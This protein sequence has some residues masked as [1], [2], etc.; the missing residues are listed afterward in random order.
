MGEE[1]IRE[2]LFKF[3]MADS[4]FKL[5]EIAG[6]FYIEEFCNDGTRI[7]QEEINNHNRLKTIL[8]RIYSNS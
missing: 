7:F 2:T 4:C 3:E 8:E 5:V 1:V 6:R